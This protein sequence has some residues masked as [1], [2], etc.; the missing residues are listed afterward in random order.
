[1]TKLTS[2]Q[3]HHFEKEGYVVIKG[4]LDPVVELDPIIEEYTGVLDRLA[5]DLYEKGIISSAHADQPFGERFIRG[6]QEGKKIIKQYFDF[7]L[8]PKGIREDRS[9]E[10]RVGQECRSR[11]S[12]S[13]S[14]K[15]KKPPPRQGCRSATLVSERHHHDLTTHN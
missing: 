14:K 1:M 13:H 2:D 9:E 8:P 3:S 6:S 4:L 7:S 12:P 15:Q 5:G 11:W 10:R